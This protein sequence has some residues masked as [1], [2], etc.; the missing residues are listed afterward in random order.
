MEGGRV[1]LKGSRGEA[2]DDTVAAL[3]GCGDLVVSV[4]WDGVCKVW[5]RGESGAVGE[6]YDA[7]SP[8]V[9]VAI[10][11][12]GRAGEVFIVAGCEDGKVL[13]WLYNAETAATSVVS[14]SCFQ[15]VG[16]GVSAVAFLDSTG[17]SND[18]VVGTTG[19]AI[20]VSAVEDWFRCVVIGRGKVGGSVRCVVTDGVNVVVGGG[21]G[22]VR[23][24]RIEE[25]G[26]AGEYSVVQVPREEDGSEAFAGGNGV[27]CL[28]VVERRKGLVVVAVGGGDGLLGVVE[29]A[30]CT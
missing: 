25:G 1:V 14:T 27:F 26:K 4:G 6:F 8:I 9:C 30:A 19:G 23:V 10:K 12:S 11:K 3:S 17:A 7:T 15:G 22:G 13:A 2:H 28:G 21:D 16:G 24:V 20:V 18:F 29:I 5:K